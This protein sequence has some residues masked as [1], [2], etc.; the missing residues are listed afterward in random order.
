MPKYTVKHKKSGQTV[1]FN[2]NGKEPPTDK[3]MT[4]VFA[5]AKDFK[6]QAE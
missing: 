5:A 6:P 1:N 2:W 3:D 4:K